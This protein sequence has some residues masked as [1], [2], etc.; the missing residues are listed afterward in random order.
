MPEVHPDLCNDMGHMEIK[1]QDNQDIVPSKTNKTLKELL[2]DIIRKNWN[3]T[4]FMEGVRRL[5]HQCELH[6]LW[7]DKWLVDFDLKTG[8]NVDFSYSSWPVAWPGHLPGQP[9]LPML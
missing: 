6:A 1:K 7:A 8:P 9:P 2:S 4:C 3:T 5:D